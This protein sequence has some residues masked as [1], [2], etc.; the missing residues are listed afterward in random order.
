VQ[1]AGWT[2]T[3]PAGWVD[4]SR[5]NATIYVESA[6]DVQHA[7]ILKVSSGEL[8]ERA[9]GARAWAAALQHIRQEDGHRILPHGEPNYNGAQWYDV[10]YIRTSDGREQHWI[11][12]TTAVGRT[13]FT[14]ECR[15]L[16]DRAAA[17]RPTCESIMRSARHG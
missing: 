6:T 11:S 10:E 8:P 4:V 5:D 13:Y 2:V 9:E 17:Q 1:E 16:E 15:F 12:R 3:V 7:V 14:M